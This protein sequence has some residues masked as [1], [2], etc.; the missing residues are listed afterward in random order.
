MSAFI[1]KIRDL[2]SAEFVIASFL[3]AFV[4]IFVNASI[5][6]ATV[7]AFHDFVIAQKPERN[8]ATL[9]TAGG[10][11][12]AIGVL[13]FLLSTLT[14]FQRELLEGKHWIVEKLERLFVSMQEA[15]RAKV[16]DRL[17]AIRRE[18]RAVKRNGEPAQRALKA[19]RTAGASSTDVYDPAPIDKLLGPAKEK[20]E[21][22]EM[23][24]LQVIY[25]ELEAALK[26]HNANTQHA[27]DDQQRDFL[28][29]VE[30][31]R[32]YVEQQY[33][34]AFNA[35]QYSFGSGRKTAA[36]AIGNVAGALAAYPL[37]RYG[38]SMDL[39]WT[40]LQHAAHGDEYF[41]VVKS[42]KAQLDALI[43][44]FWLLAITFS[45]WSIWLAV[46]SAAFWWFVGVALLGPLICRSVYFLALNS[47]RGFAEVV[48][49]VIDLYRFKVLG[50]LH[51]PLPLDVK[52]ERE[53]WDK[54]DGFIGYANDSQIAYRH[55]ASS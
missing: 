52:A 54:L 44:L 53:L 46:F 19:A 6:F 11:L 23:A 42:A 47:Y 17:Q 26:T 33:I 21:H 7:P 15:E 50:N 34:D 35:M 20:S 32:L 28:E 37:G 39:F 5:A 40:R 3:P 10:A 18:R 38:M 16:E 1:D 14:T 4:A 55:E 31:K 9:I 22:V 41:A 29:L 49:S 30:Q 12:F 2:F 51:I 25:A 8:V 43:T 13:A 48:R 24:E 45:V 36:T 27:L